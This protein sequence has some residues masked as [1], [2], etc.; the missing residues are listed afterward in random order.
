MVDRTL[1][2]LL[3]ALLLALCSTFASAQTYVAYQ[4]IPGTDTG[5]PD[6]ACLDYAARERLSE[7]VRRDVLPGVVTALGLQALALET[8]I[9]PGGYRL[10]ADPCFVTRIPPSEEAVALKFAA[11]LGYLLRQD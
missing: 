7:A 3:L 11:A 5:W 9:V 1:R 10:K 4:A 2:T 6:I 8:Q